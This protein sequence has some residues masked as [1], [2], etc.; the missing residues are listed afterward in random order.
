MSGIEDGTSTS[1]Y[2]AT[3]PAG[4]YIVRYSDQFVCAAPDT[5]PFVIGAEGKRVLAIKQ[6]TDDGN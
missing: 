2:V 6:E 4:T 5:E 3:I 1:Q